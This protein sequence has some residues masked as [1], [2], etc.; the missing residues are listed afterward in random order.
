MDAILV[1]VSII[2][3]FVLGIDAGIMIGRVRQIRMRGRH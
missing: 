3:A 2:L 1:F